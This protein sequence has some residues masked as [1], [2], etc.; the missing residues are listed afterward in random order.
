MWCD[1]AK[2]VWT[3]KFELEK[4]KNP[5]SFITLNNKSIKNNKQNG[6]SYIMLKTPSKL[7]IRFQ[8]CSHFIDAQ[9]NRIQRKLN[10]IISKSILASLD[11]FCLITSHITTYR[12]AL[13]YFSCFNNCWSLK[14]CKSIQISVNL[15]RPPWLSIILHD[16]W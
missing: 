8:R 4:N 12:L 3:Q 2:W 5:V 7:S 13:T 15:H 11:S 9:I 14:F 6:Q 10:T 16:T 1:Q